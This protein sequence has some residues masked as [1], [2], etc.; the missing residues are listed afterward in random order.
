MKIFAAKSVVGLSII[1]ATVNL[2]AQN[3]TDQIKVRLIQASHKQAEPDPQL[4]DVLPDL[5]KMLRW[6]HYQ[7]VAVA[8]S[9]VKT[10][11]T[12]TLPLG[13]RLKLELAYKGFQG[14]QLVVEVKLF[15]DDQVVLISSAKLG[16]DHVCIAG[17]QAGDEA[18]IV[19]LQRR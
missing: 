15:L 14:K 2:G 4:A 9:Q 7:Q 6:P 10:R 18:W 11:G 12:D 1:L 16:R 19:D 8:T 3:P 5:K 13:S 17:S